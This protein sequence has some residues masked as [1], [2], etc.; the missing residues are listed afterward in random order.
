M[1]R[2]EGNIFRNFLAEHI[3]FCQEAWRKKKMSNISEIFLQNTS[4]FA[5]ERNNENTCLVCAARWLLL[6]IY[7]TFGAV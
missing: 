1:K 5:K 2:K 7:F 3:N 6:I 4:G